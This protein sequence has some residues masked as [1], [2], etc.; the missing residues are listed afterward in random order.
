MPR[1]T[2]FEHR[3]QPVVSR[4]AF[5]Q[6]LGRAIGIWIAITIGGLAIGMTGYA[7]FEGMSLTDAFVN[8]AMILSGMG[9]V[10][11]LKTESGKLFAGCYAIFSGLVI[12]IATG[13][14][15]APIFHRVLH[16]FHVETGKDDDDG[17]DDKDSKP[18]AN[19]S[20]RS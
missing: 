18:A 17:D 19:R 5:V 6:R 16:R 1:L 7:V 13:F 20:R 4:F 11:E 3:R 8:A 12:V 15:L 14:V 10:T 2:G 9:P